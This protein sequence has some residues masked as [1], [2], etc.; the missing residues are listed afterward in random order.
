MSDCCET[1]L[2]AI[3]FIV[4]VFIITVVKGV[5]QE[6]KDAAENQSGSSDYVYERNEI[7]GVIG[8]TN[9]DRF[10]IECVLSECDDFTKEKNIAR[11]QLLAKKYNLTYPQGIP[12]LYARGMKAHESISGKITED[13]LSKIRAQEQEEF[14]RLNRYSEFYGRD[15]KIAMLTDRMRELRERADSLEKGASLLLR[16]T[17]QQERDWATWGG[18]AN[19]IAG[20]GAGI[21]TALEIQAQNAQ[22]RAQNEANM[23]AAMPAYMSVTG[24]ASQNR[25][26]AAAI[27][28]QI[29]RMEE[30]L[31]AEIS[32]REILPLL[33]VGNST[34]DVSE[35]GAFKV[36]ATISVCQ[37][38][39]IYGDVPAVVDGTLIAHVFDGENR[40]GTAKM[41]LPVDGVSDK[42]GIIGAGLSGAEPG[43]TYRVKY[44]PHKLWLMEK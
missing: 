32:A 43:K 31:V 22:I 1:Y 29:A 33:H 10:F 20:A 34:V 15:K 26:N 42:A 4:V 12:E 37:P 36:T 17:Q 35:T 23:R 13:K 8:G 7:S 6:K 18:I 44:A 24:N 28:K 30:K 2:F 16:S 9:L 41:V 40:I 14:N 39:F 11:A 19:G 5:I 27:E 3:A 21:S 38:L 25:S